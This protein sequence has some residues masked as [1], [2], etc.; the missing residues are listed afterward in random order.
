MRLTAEK[1]IEQYP[2]AYIIHND[3]YVDDSIS[4]ALSE[5]DGISAT[6]QLKSL[7]GRFYLKR[8]FRFR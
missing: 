6:D 3:V 5:D 1:Y 7:E 4:G 8:I 2:K